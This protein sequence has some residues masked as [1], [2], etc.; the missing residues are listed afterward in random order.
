MRRITRLC[1]S[2]HLCRN[3][4]A[5]KDID[6]LM[7]RDLASGIRSR[8]RPACTLN[9]FPPIHVQRVYKSSRGD[10]A[11][12]SYVPSERHS[13]KYS[14]SISNYKR[15]TDVWLKV[16]H[17]FVR[18]PCKVHWCICRL[19]W[20]TSLLKCCVDERS[21]CACPQLALCG[22]S[23]VNYVGGYDRRI[24]YL[25]HMVFSS[26]FLNSIPSY[27]PLDSIDLDVL[28]GRV[29]RTANVAY[30]VS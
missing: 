1:V 14:R 9:K 22:T 5:H 15:S 3:S 12:Q 8:P 19:S 25:L 29:S 20:V 24:S 4:Y 13:R 27:R 16:E 17:S 7:R 26:L 28:V 18:A 21:S 30:P 11:H 2:H 6:L 10:W 23:C